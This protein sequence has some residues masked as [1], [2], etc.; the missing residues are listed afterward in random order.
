MPTFQEADFYDAEN[1]H[2]RHN[3]KKI[4]PPYK[5]VFLN[6]FSLSPNFISLLLFVYAISATLSAGS[7]K[8]KLSSK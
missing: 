8:K 7:K 6:L 3:L 4:F 5:N 2:Q 1:T